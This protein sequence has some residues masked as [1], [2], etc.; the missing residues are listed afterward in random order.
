VINSTVINAAVD[1]LK[2][3]SIFGVVH[4]L[5][6][7]TVPSSIAASHSFG[8]QMMAN[9]YQYFSVPLSGLRFTTSN[10]PEIQLG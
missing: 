9:P 7:G 4:F 10:R 2:T 8:A 6:A 3:K 1:L 5:T